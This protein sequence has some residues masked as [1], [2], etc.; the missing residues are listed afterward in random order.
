MYVRA[1]VADT[2]T[3]FWIIAAVGVV[4]GLVMSSYVVARR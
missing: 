3:N 2:P 4:I 1:D